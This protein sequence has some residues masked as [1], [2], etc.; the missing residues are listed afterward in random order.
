M[1]G[2]EEREGRKKGQMNEQMKDGWGGKMEGKTFS[3]KQLL[4]FLPIVTS[5]FASFIEG[6]SWKLS[7]GFPWW[8]LHRGNQSTSAGKVGGCVC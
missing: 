7:P 6:W 2:R 5:L 8:V 4:Q 3:F 1:G